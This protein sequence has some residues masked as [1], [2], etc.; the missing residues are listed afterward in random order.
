MNY[1]VKENP[2]NTTCFDGKKRKLTENE[3]L[4]GICFLTG[5]V[6]VT[7]LA[8]GKTPEN[9]LLSQALSAVFLEQGWNGKMLFLQC[10]YS[11]GILML[12][13]LFLAYTPFRKLAFRLVTAYLGVSFGILFKLFFCWYGIGGVGLLFVSVLPHFLFYWMAYGLLYW[14]SDP[15]RSRTLKKPV[16]ILI[17]IGVVIMGIVIE[18]YVNPFLLRSYLKIFSG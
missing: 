2:Y 17:A 10:L 15:L 5:A 13:L 7:I 18:S 1:N 6:W 8:R 9:T 3:F 4:F 16:G 11:R 14:E 12:L